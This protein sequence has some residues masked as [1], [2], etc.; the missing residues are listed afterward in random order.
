[1][2]AEPVSIG[3]KEDPRTFNAFITAVR[4]SVEGHAQRKNYTSAGADDENQLLRVC[5]LL[6]IHDHHAIGEIIY[7]AVEF[8]KAPKATR[9]ILLEKIAGW[10]FVL[11][12]EL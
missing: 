12:R 9:K 3:A 7:K 1:M 5:V 2:S 6:G 8:L 10:A 11:W 4:D